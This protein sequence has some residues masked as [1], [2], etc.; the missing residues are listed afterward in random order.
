MEFDPWGAF[1]FHKHILFFLLFRL[2]NYNYFLAYHQEFTVYLQKLN[3][4]ISDGSRNFEK[5]GVLP[6]GGGGHRPKLKKKIKYFGSQIMSFTNILGE[7]GGSGP[8]TPTPLN[9][10]LVIRSQNQFTKN[11]KYYRLLFYQRK[12]CAWMLIKYSLIYFVLRNE[13]FLVR[14]SWQR[15]TIHAHWNSNNLSIKWCDHKTLRIYY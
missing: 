6:K 8:P 1:V 15:C 3:V 12:K 13:F 14:I 5:G 10:P 4:V 11:M 9:P 7:R 2:W